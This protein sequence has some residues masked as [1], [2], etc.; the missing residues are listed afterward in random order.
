MVMEFI[1]NEFKANEYPIIETGMEVT[2]DAYLIVE[3]AAAI[4]CEV[5]T[6]TAR[7]SECYGGW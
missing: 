6:Q 7:A 2:R 5:F 4:S 3:T 1:S